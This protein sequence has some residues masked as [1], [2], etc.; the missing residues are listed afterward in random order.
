[1][2]SLAL[3]CD[4][5]I[6]GRMDRL[7]KANQIPAQK[8][9]AQ[10]A[11]EFALTIPI[12]LLLVLGIMEA[13]WLLFT[14]SSLTVA[15]REAARYGAGIG[16]LTSGGTPLY[17]DCAGIKGAAV[18]LGAYA[19]V[20][21]SSVHIYHSSGP[22]DLGTEYC[23]TGVPTANFVTGDRIRVT[24]DITYRPISPWGL[25]PSIPLKTD[26]AHSVLI[27]ASVE[28]A[29]QDFGLSTNCDSTPYKISITGYN[30]NTN[31]VTI[32]NTST[33]T[34]ALTQVWIVWDSH[35]NPL[36]TNV[37]GLAVKA[38][39]PTSGLTY[40][41]PLASIP[42][43]PGTITFTLTFSAVPT[44]DPS[45]GHPGVIVYFNLA[46]GCSFGG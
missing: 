45:K 22:S 18:R 6:G 42:F 37:T 43:P 46:N 24:I 30:T 8:S 35:S 29:P 21:A 27:G 14:Y 41:S 1:M 3:V 10:A 12:V 34:T 23:T 17:N 25:V 16:Q 32:N 31:T 15:G 28:A 38:P 5:K 39:Y 2:C 13:G 40:L 11:V 7:C 20:T 9:R 4:R 36:L 26:S 19:G 44:W 33:T